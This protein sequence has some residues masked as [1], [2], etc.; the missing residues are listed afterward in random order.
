MGGEIVEGGVGGEGRGPGAHLDGVGEQ[1][2]LGQPHEGHDGLIDVVD[3]ADQDDTALGA[4]LHAGEDVVLPGLHH[5]VEGVVPLDGALA[6]EGS[7]GRRRP[8]EALRPV[9]VQLVGRG[10]ITVQCSSCSAVQNGAVRCSAL[11]YSAVRCN[12]VA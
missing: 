6:L 10:F 4:G 2:G 11:Q 12:E 8:L 3:G 7:S 1:D 9:H 5:V